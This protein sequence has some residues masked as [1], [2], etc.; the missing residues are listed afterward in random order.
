LSQ[1]TVEIVQPCFYPDMPFRSAAEDRERKISFAATGVGGG[2]ID[3]GLDRL[4]AGESIAA[5]VLPAATFPVID[6]D[7]EA[8]STMVGVVERL[9]DRGA[10]WAGS[11]RLMPR[12]IGCVDPHVIS[13]QAIREELA[14]RGLPADEIKVEVPE[15]WQG[16]ERPVMV[17]RHPLTGHS[18]LSGFAIEAGRWCVSLSRHLLGCVIVGRDGIQRALDLH[19]HDCAARALG[20]DDADWSGLLAHRRLWDNLSQRNRLIAV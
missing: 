17:V 11:R 14:A 15:L 18:R 13:N 2:A 16:L 3:D 10:E 9:L 4:A 5:L 12:D 1:D 20:G 19:Q 7:R 8:V 6:V